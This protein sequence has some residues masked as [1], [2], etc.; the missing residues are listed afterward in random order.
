MV[1]TFADRL[2]EAR[3][4][5]TRH[6]AAAWLR[7]VPDLLAHGLAERRQTTRRSSGLRATM[8]NLTTDIR[9]GLRLLCR[10]PGFAAAAVLTVGL[11]VGVNVAIFSV[12]RAVLINDLP[13]PEPGQLVH[14][15]LRT[16]KTPDG[17]M[18]P[19]IPVFEFL[20]AASPMLRAMVTAVDDQATISG[21]GA[22][23]QI[24]TAQLS[25]AAPEVAGVPPLAGRVFGP[26]DYRD[27]SC[28]FPSASGDHASIVASTLWDCESVS[29]EC[30]TPS[31]ASCRTPSISTSEAI[32]KWMPGGPCAG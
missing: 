8:S 17:D 5:G 26:E 24:Q 3:R 6:A 4:Q 2:R 12:V 13:Y 10:R 29:M 32:G 14:V 21:V 9:Y 20:Q 23:E 11:G 7:A 15:S 31:S 1:E 30:R 18:V 19:S 16:T 25:L 28:S 22:P 27:T